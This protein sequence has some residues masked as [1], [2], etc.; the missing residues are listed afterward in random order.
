MKDTDVTVELYRILKFQHDDAMARSLAADRDD[1]QGKLDGATATGLGMAM[2]AL[3]RLK[4]DD[5]EWLRRTL[6]IDVETKS[7]RGF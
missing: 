2:A 6:E 3:Y 7:Q 4:Q 1:E 5:K